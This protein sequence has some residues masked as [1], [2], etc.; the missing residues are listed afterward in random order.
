VDALGGAS[1]VNAGGR[2]LYRISVVAEMLAIHPQTLRLY[3]R[4]GLIR[5][6]RTKGRTRLYSA[7]DVE[8]IRR[9]LRLSRDLGVNLA[10]VEIIL[11]MRHQVKAMQAE[12]ETLAAHVRRGDTP[13]VDRN[14]GGRGGLVR[15]ADRQLRKLDVF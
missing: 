10:G 1:A 6:S 7:E 3:E 4:K 2:P 12:L 11:K 5:P 9:I 15:V 8:E 13:G 14:A